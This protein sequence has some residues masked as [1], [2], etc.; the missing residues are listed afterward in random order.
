MF[1]LDLLTSRPILPTSTFG[2]PSVSFVHVSPPSM[3]FH[4]PLPGPPP[5]YVYGRRSRWNDAAYITFGFDG[6]KMTSVNPVCVSMFL[7]F[8]QVR[9]PSVVLNNP[10]SPP[11][12]PSGPAAATNTISEL[13]GLTITL[14]MCSDFFSPMFVQV[15]PPFSDL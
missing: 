10:R 8:F 3:L 4:S 2:K 7:T 1:G 9:P 6:S 5:T 14:P 12:P 15:F 13:V 11:A